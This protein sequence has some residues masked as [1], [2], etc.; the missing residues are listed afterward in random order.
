MGAD[1][2][3]MKGRE[4]LSRSDYYSNTTDNNVGLTDSCSISNAHGNLNFL[5]FEISFDLFIHC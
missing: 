5:F 1:F 3:E 4:M 2:D